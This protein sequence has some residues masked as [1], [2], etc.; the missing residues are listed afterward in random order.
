[1]S[2][3]RG[4]K[5]RELPKVYSRSDSLRPPGAFTA[6]ADSECALCPDPVLLGQPVLLW[7]AEPHQVVH[8][9]CARRLA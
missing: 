4:A 9:A 3:Q 1:M 5:R 2:I 7:T 6:E 8:F